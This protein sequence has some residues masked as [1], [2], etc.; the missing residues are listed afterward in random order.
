MTIYINK[1]LDISFDFIFF[2]FIM[3]LI[4]YFVFFIPDEKVDDYH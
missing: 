1:M 3:S 2:I 4:S